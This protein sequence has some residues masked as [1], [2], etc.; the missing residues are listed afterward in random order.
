MLFPWV[1]SLVTQ[2]R[3]SF[4]Q[5][6]DA[7]SDKPSLGLR[8][9]KKPSDLSNL[10]YGFPFRIFVSLLQMLSKSLRSF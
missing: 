4:P 7:D 10:S 2:S 5:E 9:L 6:E 8:Q 3:D 1:L